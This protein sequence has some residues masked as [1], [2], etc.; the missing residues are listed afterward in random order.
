VPNILGYCL[1]A[2]LS[3]MITACGGGGGGGSG[4]SGSSSSSSSSSSSGGPPS[5]NGSTIVPPSSATLVDSVG[6]VWSVSGGQIYQDGLVLS[7]SSNVI[8]ML[9]YN[10]GIYQ[11]NSA[12]GVWEYL[13]GSNWSQTTLPFSGSESVSNP[14]TDPAIPLSVLNVCPGMGGIWAEQAGQGTT[15]FMI[16]TAAGEFFSINRNNGYGCPELYY[17]NLSNSNNALSGSGFT[18]KAA[19]QYPDLDGSICAGVA[20]SIA[21]TGVVTPRSTISLGVGGGI[22]ILDYE[23]PPSLSAIAGAHTLVSG[24]VMT[25]ATDG[26]LSLQESATGC[27]FNGQIS[28]LDPFHSVYRLNVTATNCTTLTWW[29]GVPEQ[30]IISFF[31]NAQ[32]GSS[33]FVFGG[34]SFKDSSGVQALNIFW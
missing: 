10:D 28:I 27:L 1:V 6:N 3:M 12:C 23:T 19:S 4:S 26:T 16:S 8:L 2:A 5:P 24:D 25:I 30:G 32:Y 34:T 7:E 21:F 15:N 17:G 11:Q 22:Y 13:G 29:N 31:A 9:Y 14:N 18:A 20:G 33:S